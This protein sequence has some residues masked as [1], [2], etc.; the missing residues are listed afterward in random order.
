MRLAFSRSSRPLLL[1]GAD[2][3]ASRPASAPAARRRRVRR[4]LALRDPYLLYSAALLPVAGVV[5]FISRGPSALIALGVLGLVFVGAQAVLGQ[6]PARMRPLTPLGWSFLRLA[7]ALLLVAGIVEL[8]GG[9]SGPLAALFI[10]VVVAAAALGPVQAIVIGA[11]A[12][13]IYLAPEVS[14]IGSTA[15]VALRGVTLAGVSILV[16]VGTRQLVVAL[17]RTSRRLRIA[18]VAD[19]RRARQITGMEAVSRLLIAGGPTNEVM[20]GALGLLVDRFGYSHVSIYLHDGERLVLGAQRGYERPIANF[21]GS[22]GVVGRVMR[23]H[24]LAFVP[25]VAADPDYIAVFDEVVSEICAPLLIDGEFLGILNVESSERLDRTDRDLIG[26]LAGR[27]ATVVA[28]GRDRHALA[29]RAAVLRSLNEFTQAIGAS[30]D[31]DRF[32]AT[33]VDGVRKV[34]PAD[35]VVLTVLD[36]ASGRYQVRAITDVDASVLGGEVKPGEGLA[37]R[38]IRDRAVV[39]DGEFST[40]QFPASYREGKDPMTVLGAGVPLVRD[41]V[42]VGA[43]SIVRRDVTA[44]FRPIEREAMDLLA[45]HAALALANAFLHA[46]VE[47]LAIRDPLTGLYNR[48]YFDEAVDRMI[49]SWHRAEPEVRRPVAAIV[50][51]LDHFGEFNKRHGHQIGDLVLRTF[52]G[53]LRRRFRSADLVARLGGEEFIV[54][55]EGATRADAQRIAEEVRA[56]LKAIALADDDG[57]RL[58]V[59]VSAGCTELDEAGST[60][61][62]LLRTADV[63][64]FMAKRAGRDR[65]VAA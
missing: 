19:R 5:L 33:V 60:R 59:T 52:A 39:I 2:R 15:E 6:I 57:N 8:S 58:S 41:G 48:R 35:I 1:P 62:M 4:P 63:A 65:V 10:P 46:E 16:A 14:R 47:E 51:D 44:A 40:E 31:L 13:V 26:T 20:D 17:E 18:M 34:V 45:G 30:L 37:G 50:F 28:L 12:S 22:S 43:L 29:E 27:V 32:G 21:D 9:A 25:D 38:A 61:E 42:V 23:S 7:L 55:L 49:A 64:L 24:E 56:E 11:V 53:M 36:Q 3:M 54:L